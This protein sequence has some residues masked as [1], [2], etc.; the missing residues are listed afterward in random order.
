MYTGEVSTVS[1][2]AF[3]TVPW[4]ANKVVETVVGTATATFANGNSATLAYTVTG[5]SQS[6]PIARQIFAPPGTIC[7]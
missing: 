6:K 5:V 4:N 2:Q 1:G 3:N 7:Q